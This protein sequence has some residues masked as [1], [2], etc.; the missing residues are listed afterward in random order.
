MR[1]KVDETSKHSFYRID[2][3]QNMNGQTNENPITQHY[4]PPVSRSKYTI[5]Y[6]VDALC[7]T[8]FF[9]LICLFFIDLQD[10]SLGELLIPLNMY[11]EHLLELSMQTINISCIFWYL[12]ML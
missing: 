9:T 4:K 1:W 6:R 7:L 10:L 2:T 3:I 11:L 5:N 12:F 8:L